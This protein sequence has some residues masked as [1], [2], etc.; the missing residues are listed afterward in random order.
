[1]SKKTL[2]A[3]QEKAL[4]S[5]ANQP[6]SG[7]GHMATFKALVTR[8]YAIQTGRRGMF[9]ISQSGCDYLHISMALVKVNY[10]TYNLTMGSQIRFNMKQ[11]R[12][13]WHHNEYELVDTW[14][15]RE[16]SEEIEAVHNYQMRAIEL[17]RAEIRAGIAK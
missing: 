3:N 4:R 5:L 7:Y 11:I 16:F 10:A 8:G 6:S 9:E 14:Y 13:G 17:A 12:L 1:M 2:N 15:R